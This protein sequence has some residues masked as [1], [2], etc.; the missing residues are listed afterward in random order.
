MAV[1]AIVWSPVGCYLYTL[2]Q[3]ELC[4]VVIESSVP[5]QV[6]AYLD[7]VSLYQEYGAEG[8]SEAPICCDG[9]LDSW[10]VDKAIG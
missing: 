6:E 1:E 2:W 7:Q 10:C 8:S 9:W 5:W 3:P 4:E